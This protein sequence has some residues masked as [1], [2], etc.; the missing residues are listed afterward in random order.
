MKKIS[1]KIVFFLIMLSS[2]LS[3]VMVFIG[4][5]QTQNIVKKY[6]ENNMN[7]NLES[8]SE[9]INSAIEKTQ[10]T[11]DNFLNSVFYN[12]YSKFKVAGAFGNSAYVENFLSRNNEIARGYAEG[13]EIAD[14]AFIAVNPEIT[15]DDKLH[16][17]YY[18]K[19]SDSFYNADNKIFDTEIPEWISEA[20]KNNS[21]Y[22]SDLTE[23]NG[24]KEIIYLIPF[25]QDDVYGGLVGITVNYEKFTE[26]LNKKRFYND[27]FFTLKKENGYLIYDKKSVS[28]SSDPDNY[29]SSD[30]FLKNGWNLIYNVNSSEVSKDINEYNKNQIITIII[31]FIFM[32][33][34][35]FFVGQSITKPLKK[36]T[37]KIKLFSEGD[38][39]TDFSVKTK[40]EIGEISLSLKKMA[41][42]IISVVSALK[43][44]TVLLERIS[45]NLSEISDE[46]EYSI[47]TINRS[48]EEMSKNSEEIS[49]SVKEIKNNISEIALSGQN[50][51]ISSENLTKSANDTSESAGS[52]L[53]SIKIMND[54]IK[55]AVISSQNSEKRA[56]ILMEKAENI[57][58][59]INVINSITEQTNLLALNAA[60]EAARAG[61]AGKGFSVVAD[62]IRKLADE[63]KKATEKIS[64]LIG[65]VRSTTTEVN[66]SSKETMDVI[67]NVNEKISDVNSKFSAIINKINDVHEKV[68]SITATF[69]E[70]TASTEEVSSFIESVSSLTENNTAEIKNSSE[71]ISEHEKVISNITN[72]SFDLKSVV[73]ELKE[74]ISF[75]RF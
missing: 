11:A 4:G 43:D 60:I 45:E 30:I 19:I 68:E 3:F 2:L 71:R 74:K 39:K 34:I 16:Y 29:T 38:L 58:S 61:E 15:M 67:E 17:I 5:Y 8:I 62:E 12:S 31:G 73:D 65:E 1:F 21:G 53:E 7:L 37:E 35:S 6:S 59:I 55:N 27:S 52:G 63:S 66:I 47:K 75:F 33:V 13:L 42:T 40:D 28:Y 32:F 23:I 25:M 41:E 48:S 46:S 26:T 70:Q 64:E 9:N 10:I 56:E 57:D 72:H 49:Y 36:L 20:L 50:I 24:K 14:S 54:Y 22:W 44:T 18:D 69:E 51:V